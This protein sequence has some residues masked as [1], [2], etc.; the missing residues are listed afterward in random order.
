MGHSAL[1][2]FTHK[3]GA[4]GKYEQPQIKISV[5]EPIS[6]AG[7]HQDLVVTRAP[8]FYI[9][10]TRVTWREEIPMAKNIWNP[11]DIYAVSCPRDLKTFSCLPV[12]VV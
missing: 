6:N 5:A 3:D 10:T 12:L 9:K 7:K 1:F 11:S 8:Q 2:Q 4:I